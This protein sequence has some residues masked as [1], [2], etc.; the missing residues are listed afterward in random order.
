M[1]I[2][3]EADIVTFNKASANNIRYIIDK[4]DPEWI[5]KIDIY[6]ITEIN[7][8]TKW[9]ERKKILID[10][11]DLCIQNLLNQKIIWLSMEDGSEYQQFLSHQS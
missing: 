7:T 9:K 5:S 10:E 1:A 4:L 2:K 3:Y 8:I 11:I 6:T